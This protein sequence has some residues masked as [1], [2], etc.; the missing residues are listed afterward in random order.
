[1]RGWLKAGR[2]LSLETV[3][4]ARS[5]HAAY[6]PGQMRMEDSQQ[7]IGTTI[8]G[9]GNI[10][11]GAGRD[12]TA[13]ATHIASGQGSIAI[14]AGRDATI[15]GGQQVMQLDTCAG[16]PGGKTQ[17]AATQALAS[18]VVAAGDITIRTG[19]DLTVV[20][21]GLHAGVTDA[22]AQAAIEAATQPIDHRAYDPARG[23]VGLGQ[24][25]SRPGGSDVATSAPPA[26]ASP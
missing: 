4:T 21:S 12:F 14:E 22:K 23:V 11:L 26:A 15:A 5:E 13:V 25:D 19:R 17:I 24:G 16:L 8:R 18:T 3:T 7:E 2:D 6:A 20:G 9:V 10:D 1:M